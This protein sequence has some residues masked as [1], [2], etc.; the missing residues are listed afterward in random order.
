MSIQS[1]DPRIPPSR[2]VPFERRAK[3]EQIAKRTLD[4][5]ARCFPDRR[6]QWESFV[7]PE[8]P[9]IGILLQWGIGDAVMTLPLLAGLRESLPEARIEILGKPWLDDLFGGTGLYDNAH[10]LVPPWTRYT[11]KYRV[12]RGAWRRYF[13]ELKSAR[14]HRFDLVVSCR[15]DARDALQLSLLRSDA[16]AAYGAAGGARW[17]DLDLGT[18]PSRATNA[19]VHRDAAHALRAITGLQAPS[20]P[21]FPGDEANTKAALARLRDAGLERGPVVVVSHSAGHPIRKWEPDKLRNLLDRF[22]SRI[23][24]LVIVQ[25]PADPGPFHVPA[26]AGVKSIVWSGSLTELR[27]LFRVADLTVCCDSGVMHIASASGCRVVAIFGPTS[28]EWYGPYGLDDHVVI[29]EPMPCR[30]CFDQCIYPEPVCMTAISE[31]MVEA[32]LGRA[33]Q[34]GHLPVLREF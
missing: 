30:P 14:Q 2:S 8:K 32:A 1:G 10:T 16:R 6:R 31:D 25:D 28:P 21:A 33:L 3:S 27:G 15:Y 18:P 7:L 12:G 13:A 17:L 4:A 20:A 26:P 29:Q 11:G 34:P 22:S 23:G 24:F 19:P 9:R 5:L